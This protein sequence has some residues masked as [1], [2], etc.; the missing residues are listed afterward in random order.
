LKFLFDT[1][2]LIWALRTPA[3]LSPRISEMIDD[4][5][6]QR[7]FSIVSLWEVVVKAGLKRPDFEFDA[8]TMR[9]DLLKGAFQEIDVVADH[10]LA[11][12]DLSRL[13]GDPFDRLLVAQAIAEGLTLVTADRQLSA[14]PARVMLV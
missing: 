3:K 1:H 5:S 10:V 13:H 7:C 11:L 6:V 9:R 4:R 8:H 12:R 14:Y 2:L